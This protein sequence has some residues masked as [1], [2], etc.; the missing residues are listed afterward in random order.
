MVRALEFVRFTYNERLAGKPVKAAHETL[1]QV[2][3]ILRHGEK[4]PSYTIVRAIRIHG[5]TSPEAQRKVLLLFPKVLKL[6]VRRNGLVICS[7]AVV[8]PDPM[9]VLS[10]LSMR[11]AGTVAPMAPTCLRCR[12]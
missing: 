5:S 4:T 12:R 6:C 7:R 8:A 10:V 1:V 9:T 3:T 2:V 11:A